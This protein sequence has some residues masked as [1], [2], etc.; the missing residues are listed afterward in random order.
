MKISSM[1]I[2]FFKCEGGPMHSEVLNFVREE[3]GERKNL[4]NTCTSDKHLLQEKIVANLIK[5]ISR[6]IMQIEKNFMS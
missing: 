6:E 1:V 2:L 3:R 4:K 5:F